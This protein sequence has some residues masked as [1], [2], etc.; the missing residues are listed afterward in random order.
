VRERCE[1][2]IKVQGLSDW[3]KGRVRADVYDLPSS[4]NLEYLDRANSASFLPSLVSRKRWW[5]AQPRNAVLSCATLRAR[6]PTQ[7]F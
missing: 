3:V 2:R 6:C 5:Y 1:W 7:S 4:R